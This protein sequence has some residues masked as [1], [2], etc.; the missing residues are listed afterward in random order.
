MASIQS[1]PDDYSYI[2]LAGFL[3][4]GKMLR[5]RFVR[6][7]DTAAIDKWRSKFSNTDVFSSICR[8]KR[9]DC[10]SD[11]IA[12]IFFDI[13]S[14]DNLKAARENALVLCGKGKNHLKYR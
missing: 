2:E 1:K 13:D 11:F 5:D 6:I 7:D 9:P 8:H 14:P 12:P 4:D 10:Q 3:P